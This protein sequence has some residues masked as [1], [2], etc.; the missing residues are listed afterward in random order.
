MEQ[1]CGVCY[2]NCSNCHLVCGHSFC[3]S[4][5]K[6]WYTTGSQTCPMCR[7]DLYFKRM[8][9]KVDE[10][11]D[12]RIEKQYQDTYGQL[13]NMVVDEENIDEFT[14]E[15]LVWV[16][17]RLETIKRHQLDLDVDDLVDIVTDDDIVFFHTYKWYEDCAATFWKYLTVTKHK[18]LKKLK[19]CKF[20]YNG[21]LQSPQCSM[22]LQSVEC[23]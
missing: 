4:C 16:E 5:V 12:E 15:D 20:K 22:L 18:R 3:G 21:T 7:A 23:I 10:W 9:Q 17:K 14:M 11:E 19:P 1:E 6:K 2:T 13:F 8:A